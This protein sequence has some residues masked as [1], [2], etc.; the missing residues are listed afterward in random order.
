MTTSPAIRFYLG[1]H[2]ANWLWDPAADFAMFVSHR[3]L[4][5]YKR[6]RPSTAPWALD[7]GGFTELSQFGRWVTSPRQYADAVAR[8]QREIG[9]LEWA[10]PQDWMC[11][12]DIIA[13]GGPRRCPR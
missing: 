2:M 8:Y 1:S 7:S 4:A 10:A 13:G 6:L 9:R 11:E 12:P 5:G 3:T